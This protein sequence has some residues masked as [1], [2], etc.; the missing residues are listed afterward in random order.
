M[1]RANRLIGDTSEESWH[2]Y[3]RGELL[4]LESDPWKKRMLI[5][6]V[7]FALILIGQFVWFYSHPRYIGIPI[8]KEVVREATATESELE[9]KF[10][11]M[12]EVLRELVDEVK[13][14]KALL[15]ADVGTEVKP[16]EEIVK[17][18]A[19]PPLDQTNVLRAKV[20][21]DKANIRP[22]PSLK[23]KPILTLDRGSEL[24]VDLQRGDWN[25]VVTPTGKKAWISSKVVELSNE[26]VSVH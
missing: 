25:R 4:D 5:A 19:I 12:T 14:H 10:V 18:G 13:R 15:E 22:S 20:V 9:E 16:L 8:E 6:T 2:P 23:T 21:V 24:L 26:S 1:P 11:Y 7:A 3:Y 17:P